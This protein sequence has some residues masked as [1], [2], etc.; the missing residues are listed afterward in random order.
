M[1]KPKQIVDTTTNSRVYNHA[2][3]TY[4]A[5]KQAGCP[6]CTIGKGCNRRYKDNIQRSWKSNRKTQWK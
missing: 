4:I 5:R 2:R 1:R 3:S 6:L